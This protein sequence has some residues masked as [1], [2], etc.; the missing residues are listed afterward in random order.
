MKDAF[1]LDWTVSPNH[2]C[3]PVP[4]RVNY[5]NWI[6]E[7]LDGER[8]FRCGG[9]DVEGGKESVTGVDI[10]VGAACV[11]PLLGARLYGWSF[12]ATGG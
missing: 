3:P 11:Y 8:L 1:D 2:L 4:S 6:H 9:G 12:V 5:L 7:I 10:G